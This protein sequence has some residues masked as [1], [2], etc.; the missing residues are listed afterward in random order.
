MVSTM[1]GP[2]SHLDRHDLAE[3]V[4]LLDRLS[5]SGTTA[6]IAGLEQALGGVRGRGVEAQLHANN[7]DDE[8][9]LAA[10]LLKRVAG[11]VNVLIHALGI[12]VALPHILEPDEVIESVSLGAGNTGRQ[13]DLE[14]DRRISEFTFIE[15]R[16]GPES[17]RQNKLF[18]DVFSLAESR[19]TKR[20]VL[21]VT[22]KTFPLQFLDNQRSLSSVLKDAPLATRFRA[23][24]GNK[25]ATVHDYWAT[26]RSRVE[27][28]DLA[29]IVPA[30][31]AGSVASADLPQ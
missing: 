12:L 27:I 29:T 8:A 25:F 16:G 23:L 13:H 31:G 28:V 11:Q 10:L 22:G 24:Y 15:W 2:V 9:L 3:A 20:R 7:I 18:A 21:Y 5:S 17:I 14:T 1:A 19:G 4:L 26:V 6:W 30:F